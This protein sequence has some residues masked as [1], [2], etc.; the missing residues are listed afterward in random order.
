MERRPDPEVAAPTLRSLTDPNRMT[1]CEGHWTFGGMRSKPCAD[2][3]TGVFP[4]TRAERRKLYPR[5]KAL[6]GR[7]CT[8][9]GLI[10][11]ALDGMDVPGVVLPG[12][13][14]SRFKITTSRNEMT[15]T[16]VRKANCS[17]RLMAVRSLNGGDPKRRWTDLEGERID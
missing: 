13:F 15:R 4:N 11:Y 10:T 9:I 2:G 17:P 5:W 12:Q 1:N 6:T 14:D 16:A 3:D 8:C 7:G